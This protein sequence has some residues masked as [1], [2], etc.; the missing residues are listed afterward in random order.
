V[1]VAGSGW[2]VVAA[3]TT[4]VVGNEGGGGS[5]RGWLWRQRGWSD[6]AGGGQRKINDVDPRSAVPGSHP[7]G[8]ETR[9]ALVPLLNIVVVD[10][11]E[12]IDTPRS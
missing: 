6:E 3:A 11:R 2:Q 10:D 7:I 5:K 4:R 12:H 9:A 1:V 8:W